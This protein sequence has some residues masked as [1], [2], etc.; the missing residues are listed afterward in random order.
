MSVWIVSWSDGAEHGPG[1]RRTPTSLTATC[2]ILYSRENNACLQL[3]VS[4][5][6][7]SSA[8]KQP[9]PPQPPRDSSVLHLSQR[10]RRSTVLA[11]CSQCSNTKWKTHPDTWN[12]IRQGEGFNRVSLK[13][14]HQWKSL[15]MFV[16]VE[17]VPYALFKS[18]YLMLLLLKSNWADFFHSGLRMC[19]KT[20]FIANLEN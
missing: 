14:I 10:R 6:V 18:F 5:S 1:G 19:L 13:I 11:C 12:N 3:T 20:W 16:T 8:C 15:K 7:C 2:H 9:G 4:A 17:S